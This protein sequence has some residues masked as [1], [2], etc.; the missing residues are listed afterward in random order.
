[1]TDLTAILKDQFSLEKELID[2]LYKHLV[3][4]IYNKGDH[5]LEIGQH[6][7][8]LGFMEHGCFM[9]YKLEDGKETAIDF[10]F[11]NSW[12]T[13]IASINENRPSEMA[14]VALKKS[15]LLNLS[16]ESMQE[17]IDFNPKYAVVKSYYVE[18]T[19]AK[20]SRHDQRMLTKDATA[21]YLDL[22]KHNP[23]ILEKVPQYHIASYLGITPQSLS[24]IRKE[25]NI[26]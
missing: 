14:I 8:Q 16:L 2:E 22:A 12:N 23:E 17:L 7:K 10:S 24:R 13:D 1:M 15:S 21:R 18:Q 9:Y 3:R 20:V 4:K 6:P 25:I 5:Y 26:A 19:F 11:E